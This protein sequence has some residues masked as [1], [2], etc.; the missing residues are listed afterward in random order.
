M[1]PVQNDQEQS[2]DS[3]RDQIS[4]LFDQAEQG[5]ADDGAAQR[6]RDGQGRFAPTAAPAAEAVPQDA[7]AAVPAVEAAPAAPALTTW[8]K[9]Y[10]PLQEKLAQGVPL[11][12]EEAK[13]LADYNVQRER[14]YST[15]I[16]TYK[17]EAQQAKDIGS[18]LGEFMPSLQQ[19]NMAPATW[20]QNMGRTH[21]TL[22][23]GSPEQKLSTFANLA[24]SYGIPLGLLAQTQQ[25]GGPDQN[26]MALLHQIN[27]IKQQVGDVAGWR[28]QQE[29]QTIQQELSKFQDATKYPHF[30][31]VRNSM[32]QL[33][34][35]G[36]ASGLDDAYEKAVRLDANAWN[37][38]QQRIAATAST[39]Q[40]ASR[41]VAVGKAKA[42]S[43]QVRSA[44]PSSVAS[45]TPAAKDRRSALAAAFAEADSGR[46]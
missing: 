19:H 46:V 4:A 16:S 13:R 24:Q 41:A 40:V 1:D 36:F 31:A 34:D 28:Q 44:A 10:L 30:E 29:Q 9:D 39:T 8:K 17:A 21:M 32:G 6:A 37:A 25:Q 23:Y 2:E 38:E 5:G 7:A 42:A 3:R 35:G 22:V 15:G 11:T 12:N 33:L 27:Q 26:T 18:V 20:I 43:G 14:E 45:A